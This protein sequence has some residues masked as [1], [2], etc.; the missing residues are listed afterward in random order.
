MKTYWWSLKCLMMT[1]EKA[2][3]LSLSILIM[4]I[5]FIVN[6]MFSS[7]YLKHLVY[8][9]WNIFLIPFETSSFYLKHIVYF[10]WNIPRVAKKIAMAQYWYNVNSR[11]MMVSLAMESP[12]LLL[13]ANFIATRGS[14]KKQP[15]HAFWMI[16]I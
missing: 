13:I 16:K 10:I 6:N 8:S 14:Y 12:N 5:S 4:F 7:F 2:S 3:Q 1:S 15:M 11:E 9:T